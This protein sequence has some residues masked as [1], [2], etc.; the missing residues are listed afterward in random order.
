MTNGIGE[1]NFRFIYI[2]NYVYFERILNYSYDD[3]NA[4]PYN[5]IILEFNSNDEVIS[6]GYDYNFDGVPEQI[7]TFQYSD[8]NL[9]NVVFSN[10]DILN[11]S[12]SSIVNTYNYLWE[13][14]IGKKNHRVL[15]GESNYFFNQNDLINNHANLLNLSKKT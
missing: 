7:N 13:N 15:V 2:N 12:Y 6:A 10:G 3:I 14:G 8:D 1:Q 11:F 9:T 4:V 5:R